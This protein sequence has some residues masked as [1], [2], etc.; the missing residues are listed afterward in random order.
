MVLLMSQ[1]GALCGPIL[2]AA[3]FLPVAMISVCDE[4]LRFSDENRGTLVSEPGVCYLSAQLER[5]PLRCG[6]VPSR[7]C[8]PQACGFTVSCRR[9]PSHARPASCCMPRGLKDAPRTCPGSA[10]TSDAPAHDA[11]RSGFSKLN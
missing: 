1:A 10:T 9:K 7:D 8:V 5:A 3:P 4:I 6:I 11:F 2:P